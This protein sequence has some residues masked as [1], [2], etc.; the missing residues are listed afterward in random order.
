MHD[1]V[2]K[3]RAKVNNF[4]ALCSGLHYLRLSEEGD[5]TTTKHFRSMARMHIHDAV[6]SNPTNA[7]AVSSLAWI[8]FLEE[9]EQ[10]GKDPMVRGSCSELWYSA[11][12]RFAELLFSTALS[13]IAADKNLSGN[14]FV[15]NLFLRYG[16]FL[17]AGGAAV[18]LEKATLMLLKG[19]FLLPV[20]ERP[21]GDLELIAN[22]LVEV[23]LESAAKLMMEK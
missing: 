12:I 3:V 7:L 16:K 10:A 18:Q 19:T 15:S 8:V 6:D 9:A 14:R 17:L 21:K 5:E 22:L 4:A 20:E 11:G 13:A 1:V 23:K 2:I